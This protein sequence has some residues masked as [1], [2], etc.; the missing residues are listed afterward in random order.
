[1]ARFLAVDLTVFANDFAADV[2]KPVAEFMAIFKVPHFRRDIRGGGYG[3]DVQ[4]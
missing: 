2:P 4:R 1:M 3:R